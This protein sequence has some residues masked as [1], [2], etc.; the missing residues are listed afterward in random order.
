MNRK[1][2]F[3]FAEDVA[4][5]AELCSGARTLGADVTAL[6]VGSLED[7]QSVASFGARVL[8]FK[9]IDG[10]MLED[11]VPALQAVILVDPPQLILMRSSKRIQCIA[12]RLA[13][14][15]GA[16]VI[17][18]TSRITFVNDT[19]QF[20]Q[21]V[22]GGVA[23]QVSQV[24]GLAIALVNA[25]VLELTDNA[26]PGVV[27]TQSYKISAGSI[28]LISIEERKEEPVNLGAAECV[29]GVGRGIGTEENLE[30]VKRYAHRIGAETACTRPI[31]EGSGWMSR[32][33]YLGV[34]GAVIKPDLYLALGVS[35]QVQHMVGV[36]DAHTIVAV[37]KDKN[38]P[39]FKNCDFGLVTD[40]KNILS[41]LE[42]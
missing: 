5:F 32:N 40:I 7:A 31:A 1:S 26:T 38:A 9:K 19:I 8:H 15:L 39:I 27:E 33:R 22:Y 16:A 12:G 14:R 18:D 6:F 29:I 11:Y 42:D 41:L 37:N 17:N 24:N 10:L 25:G 20:T 13:V 34:S 28:R 30:K 2:V 23:L 21:T 4:S 3:V 35:G 36:M